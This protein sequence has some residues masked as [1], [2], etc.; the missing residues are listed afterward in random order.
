MTTLRW[1]AVALLLLGTAWNTQGQPDKKKDRR[2]DVDLKE[3]SVAPD[4]TVQDV[5]A[6]KVVRLSELKGKPVV[7]IF[8]S[9]T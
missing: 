3:G 1:L 9:C 4:F 8:G 5:D 2:R 7:L 6:K